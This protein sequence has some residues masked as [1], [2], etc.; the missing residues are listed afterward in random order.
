[1]KIFRRLAGPEL[2]LTTPGLAVDVVDDLMLRER[3]RAENS[4]LILLCS[5]DHKLLQPAVISEVDWFATAGRR[6]GVF[7]ALPSSLACRSSW[8]NSARTR[9]PDEV[10]ARW[11]ET[12]HRVLSG[13]DVSVIG[14]FTA[15]VGAVFELG[16]DVAAA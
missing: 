12:A 3:D 5:E 10:A 8:P 16:D 6:S 7:D 14:F 11:R 4:L 13:A 2:P 15:E 9:L 1:M